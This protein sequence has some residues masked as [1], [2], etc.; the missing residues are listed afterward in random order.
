MTAAA[1]HDRSTTGI[2]RPAPATDAGP[3]TGR[4]IGN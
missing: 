2:L 3:E 4:E 1:N